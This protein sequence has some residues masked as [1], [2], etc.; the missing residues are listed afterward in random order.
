[1]SEFERIKN[2][3]LI[4]HVI[5]PYVALK[6]RGKT[7][8]AC[9]PI[10]EE[11]HPSFHV[12]VDTNSFHCFGCGA[13]GDAVDFL[14]LHLGVE[15]W[16]ALKMVA[17]AGGVPPPQ[18]RVKSTQSI[19]REEGLTKLWSACTTE[20]GDGTAGALM[21]R[22]R[23]DG[24]LIRK[25]DATALTPLLPVVVTDGLGPCGLPVMTP[26]VN[27]ADPATASLTFP[28]SE[29]SLVL[30]GRKPSAI[31]GFVVL[32][33]GADGTIAVR[34]RVAADNS[35]S[36]LIATEK[37][38]ADRLDLQLVLITDNPLRAL[39]WNAKINAVS[40]AAASWR[41]QDVR[42]ARTTFPNA[43]F[44]LDAAAL[45]DASW[46]NW[47]SQLGPRF[48]DCLVCDDLASQN[49]V[50]AMT[51]RVRYFE[52][53]MD[54]G[55]SFAESVV[56]RAQAF[57]DALDSM[58]GDGASRLIAGAELQRIGIPVTAS[59]QPSGEL[60]LAAAIPPLHSTGATTSAPVIASGAP[61]F[62]RLLEECLASLPYV[63][64]QQM[65]Q[66]PSR[67]FGDHGCV[68]DAVALF[69]EDPSTKI[70]SSSHY[71][72]A[73]WLFAR[74]LAGEDTVPES[75]VTH[76]QGVLAQNPTYWEPTHRLTSY[77]GK[78]RKDEMSRTLAAVLARLHAD[79][80]VQT[81]HHAMVDTDAEAAYREQLESSRQ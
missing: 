19:A 24:W 65:R 6:K 3:V 1:M 62:M 77:D 13:N 59:I 17:S 60:P 49:T 68:A 14:H 32:E 46:N 37:T 25:Y 12:F 42:S 41:A 30:A 57:I 21:A 73:F 38:I 9:C 79:E 75:L 58:H 4:E 15:P 11:K 61:A 7:L 36:S 33:L 53:R 55:D 10:H 52:T 80:L 18:A 74:R 34:R 67:L 69:L 35:P 48:I 63:D 47:A 39:R 22:L 28:A 81:A 71:H 40:P 44:V 20:V 43:V 45:S 56:P 27:P 23:K 66:V 54:T 70:L 50:G 51:W 29:S 64:V 26:E 76:W 72:A 8:S 31:T 2:D 16:D 78:V 5:A